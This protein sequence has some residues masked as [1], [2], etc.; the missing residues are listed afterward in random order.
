MLN[1]KENFIYEIVDD[2]A[3]GEFIRHLQDIQYLNW[4]EFAEFF[5]NWNPKK[6]VFFN[7]TN[8]IQRE[9]DVR[10]QENILTNLFKYNNEI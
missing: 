5:G 1:N 4:T 6:V 10:N 3:I 9:I 7:N 2:L 8:K